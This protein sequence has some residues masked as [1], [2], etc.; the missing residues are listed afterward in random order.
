MWLDNNTVGSSFEDARL[1]HRFHQRVEARCWF[2]Q[3]QQVHARRQCG[4]QRDLLPVPL[5]I[6]AALLAQ[7]ECEPF[8]QVVTTSL[9]DATA[10][11]PKQVDDLAA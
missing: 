8:D 7:V 3:E 6:G 5:G 4:D 1:E 9:I 11:P 2:V 10:Q